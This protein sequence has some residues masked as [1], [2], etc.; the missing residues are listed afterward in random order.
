MN[1]PAYTHWAAAYVGLPYQLGAQGPEAFDCWSFFRKVQL[2]HYGRAIPAFP[3]PPSWREIAQAFPAWSTDQGWRETAT[4]RDGDAV[5]MARMKAPTHIGIWLSDVRAVLHCAEG[6][7]S[8][9]FDA[10][11]LAMGAWRIRGYL[12]PGE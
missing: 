12:T 11:H 1:T 3:T 4:P 6:S 7:G 9:L 10:R 2:E 5:C 8:V